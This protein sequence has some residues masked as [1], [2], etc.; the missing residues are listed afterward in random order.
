MAPPSWQPALPAIYDALLLPARAIYWLVGPAAVRQIDAA[1]GLSSAGH[2][3]G[4]FLRWAPT[5]PAGQ[6][7]SGTPAWLLLVLLA[8]ACSLACM[9]LRRRL[10]CASH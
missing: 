10:S 5:V 7:L 3:L 6:L 1:L 2:H 9:L 8:S 4:V